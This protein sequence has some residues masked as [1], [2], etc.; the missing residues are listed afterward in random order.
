MGRVNYGHKLLAIPSEKESEQEFVSIFISSSIGNNMR[1][2]LP[3]WIRLDFSKE[4]Q[5]GQ[6]A[7]INLL[8]I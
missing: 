6:P 3:S 2:I 7:F 1:L 4:W 5:E 8:F